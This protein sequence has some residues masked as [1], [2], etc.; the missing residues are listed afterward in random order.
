MSFVEEQFPA[1]ISYGATGGAAFSTDIV[2]SFSG[3]EQRN[4]NWAEARMRWNVAHGCRTPAQM[5]ALIA[6]YRARRGRAV[7]FRF[8]DWSD[9]QVTAG[10]IGTGDGTAITFQLVKHYASGGVTVDR[11]IKKPVNGTVTV[12]ADGAADGGAVVD[13]TT[14][15]VTLTAA[16]ANGAIIT[17]DCEFDVPARFDT[18][19]MLMNLKAPEI[20]GW[21]DIP[22]V[23]L[24]I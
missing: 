19:Q 18:D 14:G 13:I 1:D 24:R 23:E 4:A 2:S 16:P 8:K 17:A 15:I 11:P 9:Y 22:I 3:H 21:N 6:F 10:M 12:Y 7:G 20:T 5:D